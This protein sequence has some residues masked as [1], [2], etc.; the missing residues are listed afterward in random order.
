M[1]YLDYVRRLEATDPELAAE[2]VGL[3]TLAHVMAW[4]RFR[5]VNLSTLDLVT[6]DEYSHDFL[7]PLTGESRWLSFAMTLFGELTAVAVWSQRPSA[8]EL[9]EWRVRDG[10]TPTKSLL[11]E[12]PRVLG[13][14]ACLVR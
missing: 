9:L 4:E 2:L 7:V 8:D 13:H 10:W 1:E 3:R 6:Q 12:G 11:K 14:A 5:K